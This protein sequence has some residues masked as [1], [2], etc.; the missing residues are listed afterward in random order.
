[1]YSKIQTEWSNGAGLWFGGHVFIAIRKRKVCS[2]GSRMLFSITK[3]MSR[4]ISNH[5]VLHNI[6]QWSWWYC[7]WIYSYMCNQCLSPLNVDGGFEHR[8]WRGVLD[9]P[10]CDKVCQWLAAG[11]GFLRISA[12]VCPTNKTDR[13]SIA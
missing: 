1:M 8:S 13:C 4:R 3:K 10:L 2:Y 7:S 12:A 6:D 5:S 11:R 9:T